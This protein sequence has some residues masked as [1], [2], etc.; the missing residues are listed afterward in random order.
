VRETPLNELIEQG[1][2]AMGGKR[3]LLGT[4]IPTKASRSDL[5]LTKRERA[6]PAA[7]KACYSAE[8]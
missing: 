3:S 8:C 1:M 5:L 7:G 2:S 6:A 4:F